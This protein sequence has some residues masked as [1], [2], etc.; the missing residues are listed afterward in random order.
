MNITIETIKTPWSPVAGAVASAIRRR[1]VRLAGKVAGDIALLSLAYYCAF[2][3]RFDGEV[4]PSFRDT[5]RYSLPL[6]VLTKVILLQTF[7]LYRYFWRQTSVL[8]LFKLFKALSL[9]ALLMTADYALAAGQIAFPRSI[10]LFDWGLGLAFLS[11][12]R[13]LPRLAHENS[14]SLF[15]SNQPL[16]LRRT[17]MGPVHRVLVYGAGDLA[18]T[19]VPQIERTFAGT[20]KVIGLIDDDPD[21]RGMVVHGVEVLGDRTVL[22]RLAQRGR[23]DEIVVAISNV[24][25]RQL[26]DIVEHCREFCANVQIAPGLDELFMGKVKVSDLREVQI[27]DLLGRECAKVDLDE[28]ALH[29][30]LAGKTIMV[31][32]AGGSI[33]GELCFQILKFRPAKL[34]LFGRG[35]NSIYATKHRLLPHADG[36]ELEEVIG[37]I[38]NYSK[39]DHVFALRRPQLVFHAAADKHVPM[40]E[41]NPDEAVLNNIIGTQNVL[42]AAEK[43]GAEKV[44]CISSDKAVNPTNIMGCCKRVSELLVQSRTSPTVSCAVRFGNVMGSRG[45]VIP[46]FKRQIADGGPVTITHPDITRY[47]MTIP[48]A[49][50]LVLQAGALSTGGE[51]FLL[52][53]GQPIRIT[54]LAQQ[55]IRLS[56]LPDDAVEIK[57]VGLRPG[58]KMHEELSFPFERLTRTPMPKLYRLEATPTISRAALEAQVLRLKKMGI[59]MDFP[60]IRKTLKALVPEYTPQEEVSESAPLALT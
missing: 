2:L 16:R 3:L 28:E 19:L 1:P 26:R 47:F 24:S 32:G 48:E 5:L 38:I 33:G 23:I 13:T 4:L 36:I 11:A 17:I 45:S 54:D 8:E 20:K 51:V 42:T 29:R 58:E 14:V 35:E 25:G 9:A 53:M 10:I 60:A 31:T 49:V 43:Y 46:L 52:E 39:L 59:D 56:G 41:L 6:V 50:L 37:D 18:A 44:V 55:M 57:Y 22:P 15:T 34:I 27:E 21:V 30:F 12:F 7:R 40:M